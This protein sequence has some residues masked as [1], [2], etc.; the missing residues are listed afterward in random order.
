MNIRSVA[1]FCG[2]KK[3]NNPL[4]A[5]HASELGRLIAM[6]RLQ[7]VY[8]GG[9]KGLMGILANAVLEYEGKVV[10][11]IPEVLINWES[12]HNG[13]TELVVVPDMHSRKKMMYEKSD[14][15]IVLPGG[16]GTLDEMFEMLTWNQLKLHDKKIYILNSD[17]F[18][19]H[20][21]NHIHVLQKENF[22]HDKLEEKIIFC[23][24]PIEVFNRIG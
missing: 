7:L 1:V 11:I 5:K 16:F 10:G 18:Y 4:F 24:T 6:L 19:N 13:L 15:V 14:A 3:G 21:I 2:S 17:G 9:S 12:Q 23:N 20:L 22:L 8:G